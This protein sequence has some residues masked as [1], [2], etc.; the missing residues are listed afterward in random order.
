MIQFVLIGLFGLSVVTLICYI[1]SLIFFYKKMGRGVI[2]IKNTFHFEL[3]PQ[4]KTEFFY[5]NIPLFI[6]IGSTIAAVVLF[7]VNHLET[8]PIIAGI[9]G[10]LFLIVISLIPFINIKLLKEHLYASLAILVLFFALTGF[11]A[12]YSY[13]VSKM[14]DFKNPSLI[15]SLV[16]SAL[17]FIFAL[18]FI[19]NP[20]LFDLKLEKNEKDEVNRPKVI[21]LAFMEWMLTLSSPL[22][23]IPLILITSVL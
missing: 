17:L 6:S 2:N 9:L 22:I 7:V 11:L 10:V 13:F 19:F 16:I 1:F 3:A 20:R 4:F 23:I 15:I 12:Y 14:Y 21:H 5:L 8:I 18:Y